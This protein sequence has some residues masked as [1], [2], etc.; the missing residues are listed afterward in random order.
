MSYLRDTLGFDGIV[1][2]D[3]WA[4]GMRQQVSAYQRGVELSEQTGRWLYNEALK[5]GT[6]CSAL[7][8]SSMAKKSAKTPCELAGLHREWPEGRRRGEAVG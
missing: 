5:N 7:A 4:L 2:T 1:V 3:W 6:D 8:A